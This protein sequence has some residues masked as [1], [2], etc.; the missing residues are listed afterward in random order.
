MKLIFTYLK[1][2]KGLLFLNIISVFGFALVE[3]GIPTII[4]MIIDQGVT[5]GDQGYILRM[6]MVIVVISVLGVAGTLLLGYCCAKISTS[7]T[8]DLRNDI[9]KKI[10]KFSPSEYNKFGISS[11]I[12]RTNNDAFQ[13]QLFV[14]MMLRTALLAP[15][16]IIV[17]F[18]ITIKT[19]LSLSLVIAV[20]MPIIV[21]GVVIVT[22]KAQPL[23][24]KQQNAL[25]VVNRISKENLTGVRVIRSFNNDQ[26]EQKKFKKVNKEYTKYSKKVFNLMM[27]TQ[28]L[29]FFLMNIT[30]LIIFWVA[31]IM[32]EAQTLQVG[33][34]VA[35]QEYVFHAMFSMMIFCSILVLYPKAQV[36]AERINEVLNTELRIKEE[37][38]IKEKGSIKSISFKDVTFVY[39]DGEEPVLKNISF[40]AKQ[41]ETIAFIGS[42]GSGKSTLINLV[43]RFYDVSTGEICIDNENIKQFN[44][45]SLRDKIGFISQKAMLFTGSIADNIRYGKKDASMEEIIHASKISQSHE[46][47]MSK[48]NK[49]DEWISESGANMSGGQKQRLS[50]ARAIV[51][52]PD[53]Y[54]FDDSFS[55]LDFKT[56]ALLREALKSE[57]KE[58]IVMIVAQRIS[59]IKQADQI[60]VLHEG[61]IVGKGTHKELLNTCTI[62]HEIAAS[63]LSEEELNYD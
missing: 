12:T 56:D 19:S 43:P 44:V 7:I 37:D 49:F 47:I 38:V 53:I 31:S 33:Q 48:E 28:P 55:A 32:I 62:Y 41:G 54:I 46:F 18:V 42:T 1:K 23:S 10:Q 22:R 25:D 26:H 63:Q 59:T 39:P 27:L 5:N 34:L 6:G 21:I 51:K 50:I 52:K 17:S 40:E 20:T 61:E 24:E 35:F 11:L 58:A 2:Y 8:R 36:S 4:A 45:S 3:L 16:M 29:F 15:V 30:I 14:N 57:T 60:I 13:I 9:F